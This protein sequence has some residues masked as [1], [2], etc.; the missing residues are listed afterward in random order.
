MDRARPIHNKEDI[1]AKAKDFVIE[2][3]DVQM[4]SQNYKLDSHVLGEGNFSLFFSLCL[5]F[6]ETAIN[7][8]LKFQRSF[9]LTLLCSA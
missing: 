5:N 9:K 6:S 8:Y 7:F 4:F 3:K 2:Y 1:V